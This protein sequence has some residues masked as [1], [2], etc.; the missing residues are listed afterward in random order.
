MPGPPSYP[1]TRTTG[2]VSGT[3]LDG[4]RRAGWPRWRA[5]ATMADSLAAVFLLIGRRDA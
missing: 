5:A 3:P 4:G 1:E 2:E